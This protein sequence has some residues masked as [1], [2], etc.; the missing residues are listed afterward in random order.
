QLGVERDNDLWLRGHKGTLEDRKGNAPLGRRYFLANWE[1]DKNIY[2]AGFMKVKLGPLI[3]TGAIADESSL[4]GSRQWLLDLGLQCKVQVF[5]IT[6]V[7]S[8]AHDVRGGHDV[9]YPTVLH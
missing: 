9:F 2:S 8:Y 5:G 1:F 3:D 4:F 6:V 7:A